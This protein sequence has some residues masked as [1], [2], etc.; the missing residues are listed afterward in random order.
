MTQADVEGSDSKHIQFHPEKKTE[1]V[2]LEQAESGGHYS[3]SYACRSVN[4]LSVVLL[5]LLL[6]FLFRVYCR[7][8]RNQLCGFYTH[9]CVDREC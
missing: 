1:P 8:L 6:L 9:K 2:Y 4:P 5:L 3:P 7:L